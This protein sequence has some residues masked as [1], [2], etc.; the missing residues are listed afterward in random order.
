MLMFFLLWLD[1]EIFFRLIVILEIYFFVGLLILKDINSEVLRLKG[2]FGVGDR[3]YII[4]LGWF[5]IFF[6]NYISFKFF[7]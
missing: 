7:M 2:E 4:S 1:L 3:F 5:G 6:E